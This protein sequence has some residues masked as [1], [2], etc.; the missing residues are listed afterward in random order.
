MS[1]I[2]KSDHLNICCTVPDDVLFE[3]HA[4]VDS[5]AHAS[6]SNKSADKLFVF[7]MF[8]QH[9]CVHG[10]LKTAQAVFQSFCN[11]FD[12]ANQD[13]HVVVANRKYNDEEQVHQVLKAYF[14][15]YPFCDPLFPDSALLSSS[16]VVSPMAVFGGNSGSTSYLDQARW[17]VDVYGPLISDYV[18]QMSEFLD[19]ESMDDRL[20]D[21]YGDGLAIHRWITEPESM[22]EHEY[23]VSSPVSMPLIGLVQLMQLMVLYKT[24]NV[25]PGDLACRFSVATGHSQGIISA[26]LLSTLTGDEDSF[27]TGSKKALGLW[28][29]VGAFPQL[30]F[31]Y[32]QIFEH[33]SNGAAVGAEYTQPT[34]MVSVQGLTR[35]QLTKIIV[36]FNSR[37]NGRVQLAVANTVDRFVVAGKLEHAAKFARYAKS[38]SAAPGEDQSKLP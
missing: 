30:A 13:I 29:L 35:S 15:A 32:Y 16:N 6:L 33:G 14:S 1:F 36:D 7:A 37:D 23:L 20:I 22:P 8:L 28:M 9:C 34:P 26:V 38:L 5:F 4:L 3:I 17:M 21:A 19:A 25:S 12:L 10:S 27:I 31:P 11:M 2:I 24:F 18:V